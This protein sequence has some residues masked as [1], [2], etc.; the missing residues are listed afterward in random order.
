MV[1][2]FYTLIKHGLRTIDDVPEKL[3]VAVQS[4]LDND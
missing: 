2:V 3:K 1:E 4:L